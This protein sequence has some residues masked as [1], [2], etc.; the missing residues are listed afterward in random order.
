M[1]SRGGQNLAPQDLAPPCVR[2]SGS[3]SVIGGSSTH[4]ERQSGDPTRPGSMV[5]R[6]A[7]KGGDRA[8]APPVSTLHLAV[9]PLCVTQSGH[10]AVRG[11]LGL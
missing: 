8:P 9:A 4:A 5:A 1:S 2:P 6:T 11:I 3:D 10:L 7:G